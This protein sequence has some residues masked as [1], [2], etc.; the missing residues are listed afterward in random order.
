VFSVEAIGCGF[1]GGLVEEVYHRN[2]N[3]APWPKFSLVYLA[4][5]YECKLRN[6]NLC[7]LHVLAS[8]IGP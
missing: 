5:Y 2:K 7:V 4:I 3:S 1:E 8:E 6:T